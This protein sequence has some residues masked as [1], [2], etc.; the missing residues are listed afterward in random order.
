MSSWEVYEANYSE[1]HTIIVF[2]DGNTHYKNVEN[3]WYI[4][5]NWKGKVRLINKDRK[6]IIQSISKW[7]VLKNINTDIPFDIKN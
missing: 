1:P 6:T 3:I 4:C 7:K 2:D 5:G